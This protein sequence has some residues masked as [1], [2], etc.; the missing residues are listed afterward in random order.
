MTDR[1]H[2]VDPDAGGL[3]D[4]EFFSPAYL[5]KRRCALQRGAPPPDTETG[6]PTRPAGHAYA[7]GVSTRLTSQ[8]RSSRGT[9]AMDITSQEVVDALESAGVK[10]WVL[11]GLHGYAGY[12]PTPR[13][14][15]DID[16]LVARH[17]LARAKKAIAGKWPDLAMRELEAV[18]RFV[19]PRH[20][21]SDAQPQPVVDLMAP[22]APFQ[23]LILDQYVVLDAKTGH[24]LPTLEAAVVLKYAAM[25]SPYRDRERKDYDAGDFRRLV[26]ANID[27]LRPADL[28][29]LAGLVWQQGA[30]EIDRFV[31][32][33]LSDA[34]FPI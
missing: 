33:A 7:I 23:E 15:Q 3:I 19:D 34:P 24:R 10:N 22:W 26:R 28:H 18:I 31:R 27:R 6:S 13:A 4:A 32:I 5:E 14:T 8:F 16:V 20:L 21:D 1:I 30:E 2:P 12:M 29:R 25:L 11:V 9:V 17:Q